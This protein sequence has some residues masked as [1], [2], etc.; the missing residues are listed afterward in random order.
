[1]GLRLP[2]PLELARG[3]VSTYDQQLLAG[4]MVRSSWSRL[5]GSIP[6]SQLCNQEPVLNFQK[7]PAHENASLRRWWTYLSQLLLTVHQ[8]QGVNQQMCQLHQLP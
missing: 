5:S 2:T 8:I 4:L 3:I 6:L 7:G 1:M